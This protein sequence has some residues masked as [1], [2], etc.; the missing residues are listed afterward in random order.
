VEKWKIDNE[1]QD[2]K[3]KLK[4]EMTASTFKQIMGSSL[5]AL[6]TATNKPRTKDKAGTESE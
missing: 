2:G 1:I 6:V 3:V 4:T 5:P